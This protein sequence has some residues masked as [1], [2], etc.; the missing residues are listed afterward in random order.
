MG[1][2]KINDLDLMIRITKTYANRSTAA[3]AMMKITLKNQ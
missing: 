1:T 2:F 3:E